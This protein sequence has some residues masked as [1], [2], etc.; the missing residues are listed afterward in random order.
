MKAGQWMFNHTDDGIW[1]TG[2]HYDTK[3][4]A[5]A[6]GKSYYLPE[7]R[8]TL[9]VG[10]VEPYPTFIAVDAGHLLDDIGESVYEECGEPAEDYLRHVNPE[11]EKDL[12]ERLAQ[13]VNEWMKEFGYE[14]S[15]F[16]IV[17]VESFKNE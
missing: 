12:S 7:E 6:E 9:Y 11:H 4:E 14:P 8:D 16:R 1:G 2:S 15:F 5:I 13:V 10:Q 17:N 3:E